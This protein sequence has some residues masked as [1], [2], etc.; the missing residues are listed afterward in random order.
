VDKDDLPSANM[1]IRQARLEAKPAREQL[2]ETM[3]KLRGL[4]AD[5][6]YASGTV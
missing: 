1:R 6:I 3:S 2:A 5:F 4:P